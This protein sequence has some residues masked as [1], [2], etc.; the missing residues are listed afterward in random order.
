MDNKQES[1]STP[2]EV[3]IDYRSFLT[4]IVTSVVVYSLL[5]GLMVTLLPFGVYAQF[6]I[7]I[8]TIVGVAA[9]IPL[10]AAVYLHWQRRKPD[11]PAPIAR[12]AMVAIAALVVCLLTGLFITAMAL[13]GTWVPGWMDTVHLVSAL[14][15]GTLIA[16]HLAPIV[17]RYGN[18]EASPRRAPRKRFVWTG[19]AIIAVL[20]AITG[21]LS[22]AQS[23]PDQFQAFS[24]D[25]DWPHGDDRAFWP[26]R[27]AV[28]NTPWLD[29][30]LAGVEQ[31]VGRERAQDFEA[32]LRG[33]QDE[34]LRAQTAELI[35]SLE[36]DAE[37]ASAID[38]LVGEAVARQLETGSLKPSALA[39]SATC[40]N[41]G[42]HESIYN[43]W[44]ASAH[45]FAAEDV[46]FLQVQD[47]LIEE[48]GVAESR[49]CAGCHDPAAL[50]GGTRYGAAS[51]GRELPIFEA[52]SCITCHSTIATD[53]NGNGGYVIQAPERYLFEERES[54]FAGLAAK[55]L[56]RAYPD[57]HV[58]EYKRPLYKTSEF[59]AACHKQVPPPGEATTAGLAQEQNEYDSWR[60]G[61]YFHG[62]DHPDT[63]ECIE[64]HMPLVASDDPARGDDVDSY[65]SPGDG[66]HRS[67]RVLASNMYIPAT[68]DIPGGE[69]QA[70]LTI[71]WL[72]GEIEVPEIA[73]KWTTGPTVEMQI[74]APERISAGDL[75]NI[76]LHLHNNKTGH[77]F[78]AGPLDVLESWIE[79]TV[80]DNLGNTLMELG[81]DRSISP[82]IDAP[83][84]YKAD[85]YDSQGLPVERHNLW[86]VVGASY[87]RTIRS[88]GSDVVDVPFRCP[89]IARP[90]LSESASQDTPG[91]RKSDVVFAINNEEFSELHVTARLLFRKA[92]PEFLAKV[93]DVEEVPE[94]PIVE[95]VRATH[96]IKVD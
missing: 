71:K 22:Q 18:T 58:A 29:R 15:L 51:D 55:F 81:A 66:K 32:T 37:A 8:H 87:K 64:C 49:A 43:E 31:I 26:S 33:P 69:E 13:F 9:V 2:G 48:K 74:D 41:S 50:L 83:V 30:F 65:R 86:D 53:T 88:G 91:E 39:G 27:I 73:H 68:M 21:F 36:L 67:H 85:W 60:S 96:T 90:R 45:G 70:E 11:A 59:C 92:N 95:I 3:V 93:Y 62:D 24:D 16:I 1:N 76:Q 82:S 84:V 72:R 14:V 80:E 5:S 56:I 78:P 10:V 19:V 28:A 34:G 94:A 79:L 57:K 54:G 20:F 52:N 63:V 25:Y 47:L 77:D 42:C 89:G 44:R 61:R 38:G 6:S 46:L 7:I 35:A 12:T 17:A 40:G 75:V 23:E 4:W